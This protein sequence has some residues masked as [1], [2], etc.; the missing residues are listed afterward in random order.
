MLTDAQK[1]EDAPASEPA[2]SPPG[3]RRTDG[4]RWTFRAPE[5]DTHVFLPCPRC[6]SLSCVAQVPETRCR[7]CGQ[8]YAVAE[9]PTAGA[10]TPIA[11]VLPPRG[12]PRVQKRDGRRRAG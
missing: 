10:M 1:A 3:R 6:A 7:R 5:E 8:L 11:E 12:V 2:Q 4:R 9:P